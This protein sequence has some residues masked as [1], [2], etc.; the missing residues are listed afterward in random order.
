MLQGIPARIVERLWPREWV[1]E[2]RRRRRLDAMAHVLAEQG[3]RGQDDHERG[4]TSVRRSSSCELF[5]GVGDLTYPGAIGALPR[6][7]DERLDDAAGHITVALGRFDALVGRGLTQILS[8]D[9]DLRIIGADLDDAAL[10]H[11][12]TRQS[13]HVAILDEASIVRSSVLEHLSTARPTIGII[14][15][16][17]HPTVA[18]AMRMM[19]RGASCLAKDSGGW[20]THVCG[21]RW[22]SG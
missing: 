6:S 7:A 18:Y 3:L 14:V 11:T 20:Q 9:R 22:S 1:M 4:Y 19:A 2:S 10:E 15:L 12:V 21:C 16:A 8:E 5:N 13:P 17:H